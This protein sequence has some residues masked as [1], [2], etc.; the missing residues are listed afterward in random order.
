MIDTFWMLAKDALWSGVAATGFAMLFNVP[1][2][3]LF[4]CA[5]CGAGGHAL[6]T[7][8]LEQTDMSIVAATL[9]GATLVGFMGLFFAYH[10]K[11]PSPVFTVSGSIPMVPG[12][13]AYRT[14]IH[15][16]QIADADTVAG[17]EALVNASINGVT[18]GLVLGALAVGIAAPSLLFERHKPVV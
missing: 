16:L 6:R 5:G 10:Y 2:R 12:T 17:Q 18:T 15:L 13:F 8:L 9:V 1:P 14:M 3:A 11:I 4:A 7:L